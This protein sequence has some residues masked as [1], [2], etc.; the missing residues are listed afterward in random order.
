MIDTHILLAEYALLLNKYGLNAPEPKK[1]LEKHS[2]NEEF[3]DL[4][5][6]ARYLKDALTAR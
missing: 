4:A 2:Y 3:L 5:E 6:T 1:Y